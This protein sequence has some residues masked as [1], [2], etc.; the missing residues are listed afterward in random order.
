MVR[1]ELGN[2]AE[3]G[4]GWR[5]ALCLVTETQSMFTE[6]DVLVGIESL[7]AKREEIKQVLALLLIVLNHPSI[8][9]DTRKGMIEHLNSF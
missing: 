3:T 1:G 5:D 8:I 7:Q 6:M 4:H 2:D 9:Q